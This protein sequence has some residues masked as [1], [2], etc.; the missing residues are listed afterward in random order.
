MG[1]MTIRK[2]ELSDYDAFLEYEYPEGAP[3]S[4]EARFADIAARQ[5]R[6]AVFPFSVMLKVSYAEMDFANRWC[7]QQFG[8]ANAE[9]HQAHSEYS[10]CDQPGPHCHFG[11]WAVHWYGKTDYN[12]GFH[13]WYFSSE[14]DRNRF[15]KFVPQLNWGE[16]YP[17]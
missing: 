3:G 8:P 14:A 4:A 2:V 17:K 13:E 5:A 7:W 9:C 1:A 16:H 6:M 11:R 15:L 12:F 10:A